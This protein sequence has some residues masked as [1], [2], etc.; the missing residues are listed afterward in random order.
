MNNFLPYKGINKATHKRQ[1]RLSLTF[2]G[3][4]SSH[5]SHVMKK[6]L[7]FAYVKTMAQISCEPCVILASHGLRP[8]IPIYY[9]RAP[10][11]SWFVLKSPC[12]TRLLTSLQVR[13]GLIQSVRLNNFPQFFLVYHGSPT[14]L[15]RFIKPD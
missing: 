12:F 5:T 6:K 3:K 10:V 15:S 1:H 9:D 8:M 2:H 4:S 11:V 14:V 7:I 13:P